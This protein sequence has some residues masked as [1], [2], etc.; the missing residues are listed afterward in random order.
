MN[1]ERQSFQSFEQFHDQICDIF[2]SS[3]DSD[4]Y[5]TEQVT[6][7][8]VEFGFTPEACKSYFCTF[9]IPRFLSPT[10]N[11]GWELD[12]IRLLKKVLGV[13]DPVTFTVTL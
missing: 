13:T 11:E 10:S 6:E 2:S 12:E 8:I 7:Q 1:T 9:F 5:I 4:Q 3:D